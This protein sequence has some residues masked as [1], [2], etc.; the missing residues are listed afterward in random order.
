MGKVQP[1]KLQKVRLALIFYFETLRKLRCGLKCLKFVGLRFQFFFFFWLIAQF[2]GLNLIL[3]H[4]DCNIDKCRPSS[5]NNLLLFCLKSQKCG[6]CMCREILIAK[7]K[8]RFDFVLKCRFA[9]W[10]LRC[11]LEIKLRILLSAFTD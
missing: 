3:S 4:F 8:L 2:C 7:V 1:P 9:I 6:I 11:A 10:E 5:A